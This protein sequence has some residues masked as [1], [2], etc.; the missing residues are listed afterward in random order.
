MC[1]FHNMTYSRDVTLLQTF[2]TFNEVSLQAAIF[3][4]AWQG[5]FASQ[6]G[7]I[8]CIRITHGFFEY[9]KENT[10]SSW[11]TARHV[12]HKSNTVT[13]P[14]PLRHSMTCQSHI[15]HRNT[16]TFPETRNT[17]A[18]ILKL[19]SKMENLAALERNRGRAEMEYTCY[20][21]YVYKCSISSS[22]QV[23]FQ[24]T[25]LIVL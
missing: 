9:Q 5:L 17:E 13:P 21:L 18:R 24:E 10:R 1:V 7:Y 2:N 6:P 8:N 25:L 16:S 19:P 14:H 22:K 11:D 15:Q 12:S 20:S 4:V 23:Q 3:V